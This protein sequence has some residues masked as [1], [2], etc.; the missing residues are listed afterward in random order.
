MRITVTQVCG[1]SVMSRSD[2]AKLREQI[3]R[4]WSD[5]EPLEIDFERIS[6]ASISFLDEAIA[7]LALDHPVEVLRRRLELV[8][9]LDADR[10]LLNAQ[11]RAR[12][13]TR[14]EDAGGEIP[15]APPARTTGVAPRKRAAGRS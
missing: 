8:N 4:R 13:R 11:I 9:I 2:G 3:E 15:A 12:A 5:T 1:P 14:A 10:R 7:I 6:I